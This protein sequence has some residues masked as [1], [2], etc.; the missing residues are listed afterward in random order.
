LGA[1]AKGRFIALPHGNNTGDDRKDEG[2]QAVYREIIAV[3]QVIVV[4]AE[5]ETADDKKAHDRGKETQAED[6]AH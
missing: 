2:L 1:P 5:P 6:A 4:Y 3:G